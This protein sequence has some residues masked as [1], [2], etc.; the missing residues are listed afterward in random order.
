VQPTSTN[1]ISHELLT[2]MQALTQ[3]LSRH[4]ATTLDKSDNIHPKKLQIFQQNSESTVEEEDKL[5]KKVAKEILESLNFDTI[6]TRFDA[7]TEAHSRTYNW[8]FQDPRRDSMPWSN[9]VDWLEKGNGIYWING[10]AGSGKSTLMKFVFGHRETMSHLAVW[11]KNSKFYIADFFFWYSGTTL[12]K[13][14]LGLLRSLLY[15]ILR[16]NI[17]LIPVVLPQQWAEMYY[18]ESLLM[19]P[20]V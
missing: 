1:V 17:N 18:S 14:Q 13:S 6:A 10:K 12:Q 3:L 11:A 4:E 2:Q 7:V 9:F 19:A 5:R 16:K 8:I 20:K 15:D